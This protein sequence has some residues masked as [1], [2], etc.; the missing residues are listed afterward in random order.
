MVSPSDPSADEP[1]DE[2]RLARSRVNDP[3]PEA[4]LLRVRGLAF[5]GSVEIRM[6]LP[7]ESE[8]AAHRRV[9]REAHERP[10][11]PGR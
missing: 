7:G 11:L 5:M 3:D 8:R 9:K 6:R 4:P 10:A 2:T 1:R